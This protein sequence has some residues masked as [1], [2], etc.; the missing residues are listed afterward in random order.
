MIRPKLS[1]N[2]QRSPRHIKPDSKNKSPVPLEQK[3]P[4]EKDVYIFLSIILAL[5]I[6]TALTSW[7]IFTSQNQITGSSKQQ[8]AKGTLAPHFNAQT[9]T[10]KPIN[11]AD[12]RGK[13]VLLYFWCGCPVHGRE[14]MYI[15][16]LYDMYRD[17]I[18]IVVTDDIRGNADR[19]ISDYQLN[20]DI[21][22]DP[23]NAIMKSYGLFAVPDAILIDPNG[24]I[25]SKLIGSTATQAKFFEQLEI[26][27]V[28]IAD[29]EE[30]P[31][32]IS[33]VRV[34]NIGDKYADVRWDT[35]KMA[36]SQVLI[37]ADDAREK[38]Y[39]NFEDRTLATRHLVR[40]NTLLVQ[41]KIYD[42]CD[43]QS[44]DSAK[45]TAKYKLDFITQVSDYD[46][47]QKIFNIHISNITGNSATLSWS[48]QQY[49]KCFVTCLS[50]KFSFSKQ[51]KGNNHELS[52]TDLKAGETYLLQIIA[53]GSSTK[54]VSSVFNFTTLK[55]NPYKVT[56]SDDF[57][58]KNSGWE[59]YATKDAQC[60]YVRG[61]LSIRFK[62]AYWCHS[63]NSS[64]PELDDFAVETDVKWLTR[65]PA[66]PEYY[67]LDFEE[68]KTSYYY[69]FIID[70]SNGTY[71]ISKLYMDEWYNLKK[72]TY[73]PA[74]NKY[75][76]TNKMKIA[77]RGAKIEFYVNDIL[78]ATMTDNSFTKGSIKLLVGTFEREVTYV[79]ALFDN[80]KLSIP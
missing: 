18:P 16:N 28:E 66:V 2:K 69:R 78:L 50:R 48:T 32:I 42:S 56:I 36:T 73:S 70:T 62:Q 20:I 30:D 65:P 7:I 53:V 55:E 67:G 41:N 54:Y 64:L 76:E 63:W 26:K 71:M 51:T 13:T 23:E 74:I 58:D 1:D 6:T 21:I 10:G 25:Q 35:N 57:A 34:V 15:Q 52:L 44:V 33:N 4:L 46:S 72:G 77:R 49:A 38:Y 47:A 24:A 22:K 37:F 19:L 68:S 27:P 79:E 45:N 75:S 80:F 12:L 59:T 43:I 17:I 61:G 31:L 8:L 39:L 29:N 3:Q 11:L 5:I 40:I 9:I 60:E 14:V